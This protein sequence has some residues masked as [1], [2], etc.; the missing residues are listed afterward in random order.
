MDNDCDGDA[1]DGDGANTYYLDI[2]GDGFGDDNATVQACIPP[3]GYVATGGDECPNNPFAQAKFTWYRDS[4]GDLFGDPSDSLE[5]CVQP[6]GYVP[7]SGDCDDTDPQVN[8]A[9]TEVCNGIDDNC[10]G[11]I[12]E[13]FD[14]STYYADSD[15][16]GFGDPATA[17]TS[18]VPISGQVLVAGDCDDINPDAFPGAAELCSTVGTD[19]NCNDDDDDVD[20][21]ASDRVLFYPDADN[22]TFTLGTGALF[23]PGTDNPGYR[24][25]VSVPVDCNDEDAYSYPGAPETC[26]NAG[27]DN[28]CNG[29]SDDVD[30]DAPD[31]TTYY[32]DSDG[33]GAGDSATATRACAPPGTDWI[34]TGGDNC[35]NVPNESQ[36][37]CDGD[38]IG[39]ACTKTADCNENGVPDSCEDG[40]VRAATGAMTFT[41]A[42]GIA[43]AVLTG[44]VEATTLVAIQLS[45]RAD[46]DGPDE[47]VAIRM[48]GIAVAGEILR[49]G[50]SACP[51]VPDSTL[52]LVPES[53]WSQVLAAAASPGVIALEV[54]PSASVD[55]A[56]CPDSFVA[57]V[58]TYG[59]PAYDCD[60]DGASD[61]CQLAS[62]DGDCD[63]NGVLDACEIGGPG[64]TDSDGT[65]DSCEQ[66]Y[67]DFN[68][69][70]L[71]DN[72][73]LAFVLAA[74]DFVGESVADLDQDGDVDGND[75]ALIL[76][77]WGPVG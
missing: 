6:E 11:G 8:P 19:N 14:A 30:A 9:A 74:W 40:S 31:A 48:N 2:D 58:V 35:P 23:C 71:V 59:G 21:D 53:T 50:A 75:L 5:E 41:G 68:L 61:L 64:D 27:T 54:I 17:A 29:N 52:V 55:T 72:V 67:G 57:A 76:A 12:D 63:D 22:D 26:A 10:A 44:Q 47:F 4:D 20:P 56:G 25:Q 46:L 32:L 69:D 45:V 24:T 42:G 7:K 66:A 34:T 39:D 70:G 65:P 18:C 60:G 38:G 37:D 43:S 28:N 33:D 15:G 3:P 1:Y 49:T 16:D 51:A 13:G 73:D 62:G 77:R 36:E